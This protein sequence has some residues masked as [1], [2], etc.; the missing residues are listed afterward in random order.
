MNK[1]VEKLMKLNNLVALA[2][3]KKHIIVLNPEEKEENEDDL[4]D[5]I[6]YDKAEWKITKEFSTYID[7]LSKDNELSTEDKILRVFEKV[8]ED[9]IYDDNLIEYT[10][11]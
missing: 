2:F 7:E 1:D 6:I 11:K 10:P 8:C 4:D 3:R 9:Y 5:N